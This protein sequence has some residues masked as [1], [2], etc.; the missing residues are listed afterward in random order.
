[1][2]RIEKMIKVIK[3][4]V[5]KNYESDH[6]SWLLNKQYTLISTEL[7]QPVKIPNHICVHAWETSTHARVDL[8]WELAPQWGKKAKNEVIVGKISHCYM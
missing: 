7:S 5:E 1:M 4:A 6:D 8:A 2:L 3:D